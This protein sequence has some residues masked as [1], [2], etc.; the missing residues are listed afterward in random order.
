MSMHCAILRICR[1][2]DE[3]PKAAKPK[4]PKALAAA[5]RAFRTIPS[6]VAMAEFSVPTLDKRLKT[7]FRESHPRYSQIIPVATELLVK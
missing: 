1:L 3:R 4:R 2:I 6:A 7:L 5:W